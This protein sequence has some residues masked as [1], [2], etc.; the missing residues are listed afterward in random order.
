M[1]WGSEEERGAPELAARLCHLPALT[2]CLLLEIVSPRALA[3]V[4]NPGP[5]PLHLREQ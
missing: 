5:G 2:P 4:L 1:P 3:S